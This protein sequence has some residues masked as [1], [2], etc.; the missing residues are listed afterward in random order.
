MRTVTSLA[1]AALACTMAAVPVF[2]ADSACVQKNRIYSTKVVDSR[3]ILITD[4][5]KK[6]Y[7]IHMSGTCVGLNDASQY[8][9]FRTKGQT[10]I[11]C[12]SSGD[13][14]GYNMPGEDAPVRVRPNV[15]T[16]CT[17]GSVT[18]GAPARD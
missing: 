1:L 4:T 9:T 12:L 11:S 5:D 16:S 6:P 18:A 7:T 10:E 13:T 2:A 14:I 15:Q 3:T 17:I 8:L